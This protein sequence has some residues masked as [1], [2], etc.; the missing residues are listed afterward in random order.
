M[1]KDIFKVHSRNRK[2][3]AEL[4]LRTNFLGRA[5]ET[6]ELIES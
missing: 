3:G 2:T 4:S 5:P 6:E 1:H